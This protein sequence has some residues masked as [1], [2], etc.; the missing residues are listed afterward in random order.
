MLPHKNDQV[1]IK[2]GKEKKFKK[3]EHDE[4]KH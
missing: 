4:M 1:T 3:Y 2:R